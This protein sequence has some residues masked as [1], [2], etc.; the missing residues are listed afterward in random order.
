MRLVLR[1]SPSSAT[2]IS[3]LLLRAM[4]HHSQLPLPLLPISYK[5]HQRSTPSPAPQITQARVSQDVQNS[6]KILNPFVLLRKSSPE[7]LAAKPCHRILIKNS[8]EHETLEIGFEKGN[9]SNNGRGSCE[10]TPRFNKR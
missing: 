7:T 9:P 2:L 10:S 8:G 1:W 5:L 6:K 3:F 4:P